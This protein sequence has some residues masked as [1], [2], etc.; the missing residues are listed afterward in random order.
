MTR[1]FGL[2]RWIALT[3]F[4]FSGLYLYSAGN[5]PEASFN[6][7]V[8]P[9]VFPEI[10]AV[11]ALAL[12]VIMF[13]KPEPSQSHAMSAGAAIGIATS[14][15]VTIGFV[16]LMP[17]IGFLGGLFVASAGFLLSL[18]EPPVRVLAWS[19]LLTAIFYVVFVTILNTPVPESILGG[20]F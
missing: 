11:A 1:Y 2:D 20:M 16:V 10:L 13:L 6:D 17:V 5:I 4:L 15:A 8:G 12:S 19:L 9:R 18:R 7:P 14:V 3:L